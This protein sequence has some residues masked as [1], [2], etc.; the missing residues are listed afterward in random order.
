MVLFMRLSCPKHTNIKENFISY[1]LYR[2]SLLNA[3]NTKI[4]MTISFFPVH[5]KSLALFF[6]HLKQLF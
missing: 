2:V 1:Y 6:A 5:P 4:W 3:I